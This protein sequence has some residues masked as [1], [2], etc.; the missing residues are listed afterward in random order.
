MKNFRPEVEERLAK[1]HE[2]R[3]ETF[4]GGKLKSEADYTRAIPDSLGGE[5]KQVGAPASA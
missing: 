2:T 1:F 4:F 5:V 3:G